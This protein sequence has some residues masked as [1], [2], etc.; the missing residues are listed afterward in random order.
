MASDA[1]LLPCL[2]DARWPGRE[3]AVCR[4]LWQLESSPYMPWLAIGYDHPHTFEFIANKQLAT[5]H[6]TGQALE[7]RALANLRRRT[8]TW[9]PLDVDAKDGK[10]LRMLVCSDD[11]F[12][13]ERIVDADFMTQAQRTLG[14]RGL[15]VGIPR[16]GILMATNG[17]QDPD[18]VTGFGGAVA[19]QFSRGET[20]I[21]SPMLF[22]VTDGAIVGIIEAVADVVVPDGAPRGAPGDADEDED[23]GDGDPDA[24]Q[25][26]VAVSRNDRGTEDVHL[27]AGGQDGDRL[28]QAIESAFM[29]VI[30][31]NAARKEF[32]GHVQIVVLGHTPPSARKNIPKLLEHLRGICSEVSAHGTKYRVSLTYQRDSFGSAASPVT[33]PSLTDDIRNPKGEEAKVYTDLTRG[34][35]AM[36]IGLVLTLL[37]FAIPAGGTLWV[38]LIAYGV[39]S[40]GRGVFRSAMLRRPFPWKRVLAS[41][42]IPGAV[43]VAFVAYV[44]WRVIQQERKAQ[45]T[46]AAELAAA[47]Q[48]RA[49]QIRAESKAQRDVANQARAARQD[50]RLDQALKQLTSNQSTVQCDA[51]MLL[52]RSGSK[53]YVPPL[54]NLLSMASTTF[55]RG[56][57]AGA[58]VQLGDIYT[59]MAAYDRWAAGSDADLYRSALVG[60]GAIGPPAAD[61]A[62]PH[63]TGALKSP[64]MDI[65]YLAVDSLAKLGPAAVP[66][67]QVAADDTDP[68]VRSRAGSALKEQR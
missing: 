58:L 3:D 6:T 4:A 7:T 31:K 59:P 5:L 25:V 52:G 35:I 2:K 10:R 68:H 40:F 41:A 50:A 37:S 67:L 11:Y 66:L 18:L 9:Q 54:V 36:A 39:L 47:D 15:L 28:A 21:I 55:V 17:E 61:V 32:S 44:G 64:R 48:A 19:G 45:A 62:L 12:A 57:A 26:V 63:L 16:R 22:A 33:T 1:S 30:Q 65:R 27:M 53:E 46:A 8:A 13:A 14:A 60:F 43:I 34:G 29:G 49:D 56:C 51:A 42:G 24:P 20:A 23:E 38:G